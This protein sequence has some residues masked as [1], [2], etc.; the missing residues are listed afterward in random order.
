MRRARTGAALLSALAM[1]VL[2]GSA[3]AY[4]FEVRARAAGQGSD[5]RAIRLLAADP[6]LTRRQFE[7]SLSL[8]IWNLGEDKK[9]LLLHAREPDTGPDLS[10]STYFRIRH[11]FGA[12]TRGRIATF[13]GAIDTIDLVPELGEQS[14]AL[15]VLYGYFSAENLADRIDVYVGRQIE[16]HALDFFAMDGLKIRLR[17]DH[18]LAFEAFGGAVVRAGSPLGSARFE[19]D[20]TSAAECAEYVEGPLVGSGAWRPIDRPILSDEENSPFANDFDICPQRDEIMPT[21]GG[22]IAVTGLSFLRARLSYRRSVSPSPE[23]IGPA[24]RFAYEDVGYYPNEVGQAPAWGINEEVLALTARSVLRFD[25]GETALTPFGGIRY[26][27]LHGLVDAARAGLELRH[28]AHRLSPEVYYSFPTFDGDSIFNVFGAAP[29]T[30]ARMRYELAPQDSPWRAHV[31][32]WVKRFFG[33][34]DMA[35]AY[36]GGA[37]IGARL[38]FGPRQ[39]ARLALYTEGGYGG[40][41]TGGVAATR[42]QLSRE[43]SAGARVMAVVLGDGEGS[44]FSPAGTL[45]GGRLGGTYRVNQGIALHLVL[46]ES[47]DP[48]YRSQFRALA[49]LDLAFRPEN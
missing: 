45:V 35:A 17:S 5:L 24:D 34:G 19:P 44:A 39:H 42:W 49:V 3:H 30:D 13:A 31:L 4:E 37:Q 12:F 6:L 16:V 28:G 41:R 11:D 40:V 23:L 38:R 22:A 21:F 33:L 9:P 8:D 27:L 25:G 7:L 47:T 10:I 29:Y 43:F 32:G 26:S 14:L 36:A 20:G 46:E 48:V 2:A 15:D 1:A 18:G